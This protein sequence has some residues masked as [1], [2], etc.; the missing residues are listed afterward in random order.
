[1]H[2]VAQAVLTEHIPLPQATDFDV[3]DIY[4]T[5]TKDGRMGVRVIAGDCVINLGYLG[6]SS[7]E[8]D[9]ALDELRIRIAVYRALSSC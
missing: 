9:A 7:W 3:R 4:V 1:M 2:P 6:C 5:R 8:I